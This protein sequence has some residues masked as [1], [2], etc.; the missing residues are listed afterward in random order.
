MYMAE[1]ANLTDGES[2]HQEM[3]KIITQRKENAVRNAVMQGTVAAI[4]Y[5]VMS[6][7]VVSA[8][9]M[10]RTTKF[11]QRFVLSS[12]FAAF[13]VRSDTNPCRVSCALREMYVF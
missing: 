7:G 1:A 12:P 9:W 5:G 11:M 2:K 4:E 8:I 6:A 3:S 10:A 13:C